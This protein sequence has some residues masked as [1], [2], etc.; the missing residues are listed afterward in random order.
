MAAPAK[1]T[2]FSVTPRIS[3]FRLRAS[4]GD[5][6]SAITKWQ[7]RVAPDSAGL[8]SASWEDIP[9]SA[10]G[11]L[12][13]TT[14]AIGFSLTRFFTV[15]AVNA[16]GNGAASDEASA[17]TG[18][19]LLPALISLNESIRLPSAN[20]ANWQGRVPASL[21]DSSREEGLSVQVSGALNPTIQIDLGAA[22][23][24]VNFAEEL[25]TNLL[26]FRDGSGSRIFSLENIGGTDGTDPYVLPLTIAERNLL[27]NATGGL[28]F[29]FSGPSDLEADLGTTAGFEASLLVSPPVYPRASIGGPA[30][31]APEL[32]VLNGIQV[33]MGGAAGMSAEAEVGYFPEAS[34]GTTGGVSVE[35][36]VGLPPVS[37]G[38][39]AGLAA[40]LYTAQLTA[41]FGTQAGLA[42]RLQNSPPIYPRASI[43]GPAGFQPGLR[44]SNGIPADIGGHAG[45]SAT[46][47]STPHIEASADLG[48]TGGLAGPGRTR[49]NRLPRLRVIQGIPIS[50]SFG[51]HGGI[52][53]DVVLGIPI[54]ADLGAHGG[55]VGGDLTVLQIP[56]SVDIGG[57]AGQTARLQNSPP[58][59]PEASLGGTGGLAAE[60][61]HAP[62]V[63][64][65]TSDRV[66]AGF[67][68][69]GG[70][71]AWINRPQVFM[72]A[73][74][75][76]LPR[77]SPTRG[78]ILPTL[79]DPLYPGDLRANLG[80]Q[81]R[82]GF[83]ASVRVEQPYNRITG[84]DLPSTPLGGA[85]GFSA[86][87]HS[88]NPIR[89]P[90]PDPEAPELP[91]QPVPDPLPPDTTVITEG[92]P[93][94]VSWVMFLDGV[95]DPPEEYRVWGGLG[96]LN[97]AG[98][99]WEGTH[100]ANGAFAA[101]STIIDE[102][103]EKAAR[104]EASVV[105]PADHVR[106][107]LEIDVGPISV[108]LSYIVSRDEGRT[109]ALA[110]VGL[111]G[112]LSAPSFDRGIYTA[113]IETWAGDA[114]RGTPK[115][116]S[117]E[118]QK[119]EYPDDKGFEFVRAY[120]QGLEARWPP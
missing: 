57:D 88:R 11:A 114:D 85:A 54:R 86:A 109:W 80:R 59:Y 40:T 2:G 112:Q 95:G 43:G 87:L 14:D 7:Y 47:F 52:T 81:G 101:V 44:V 41:T 5:G 8:A 56:I 30:G 13:W 110:P 63:Y 118:T 36:Q 105:V 93:P 23:D 17:T 92:T 55:A 66:G 84:G 91:V 62:P 1:P 16:D 67:G 15:R 89:I 28:Q 53:A 104:A 50:V 19:S 61:G 100:S 31:A 4:A 116:W 102:A 106:E 68:A 27:L 46:L 115:L 120:E 82:G 75:G 42:A 70:L 51:N 9:E 45:F 12:D 96:Q 107:M 22:R 64:L 21:T 29:Y 73:T 48:G 90:A 24:E 111:A 77:R 38:T 74:I 49:R 37:I 98:E 58:V 117:D 25:T 72:R 113:E 39:Q 32:T 3:A 69:S 20:F 65:R 33:A 99:V 34:I 26:T 78:G 83:T 79:A 6:G 35:L 71:E 119:A 103:G 10:G 94:M 18:A 97:F 76:G 108:Y 60:L